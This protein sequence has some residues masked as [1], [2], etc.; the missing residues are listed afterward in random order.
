MLELVAAEVIFVCLDLLNSNK[1]ACRAVPYHTSALIFNLRT[2]LKGKHSLTSSQIN[3][4][5]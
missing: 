3:T 1:I 4:D 5:R 2:T